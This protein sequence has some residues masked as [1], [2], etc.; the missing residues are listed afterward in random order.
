MI[1]L[2]KNKP[3]WWKKL[4]YRGYT[5]FLSFPDQAGFYGNDQFIQQV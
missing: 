5:C 1:W 4:C 2:E 3:F